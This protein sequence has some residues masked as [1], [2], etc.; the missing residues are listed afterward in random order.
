MLTGR[1][2]F[3]VVVLLTAGPFPLGCGGSWFMSYLLFDFLLP[4]IGPAAAEYW[5]TLLVVG[6]L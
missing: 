5:A 1:M 2:R 3:G 4:L 6:P